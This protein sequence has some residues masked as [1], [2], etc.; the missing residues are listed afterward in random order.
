MTAE[1]IQAPFKL[2]AAQYPIE[3][4]RNLDGWKAKI[5][6]YVEQAVSHGSRIL[7]F[8][9][10]AS[11][12]LAALLDNSTDGDLH[13]QIE[14]MQM[15]SDEYLQHHRRLAE[16][17]QVYITTA[18]FPFRTETGRYQNRVW[19]CSPEGRLGYQDKL[20]MTRF[21][22]EDWSIQAGDSLQLFETRYGRIGILVCYDSEFPLLARR[23]IEQGADIII[24]PSCTDTLAGHHRVRYSCL[25][26]ALENQC[27][28]VQSPTVGMAAWNEAVDINIGAAAI[29]TPMDYGFPANGILAEGELNKA[30]W[31]Y[32]ELDI[33]AMKKLRDNG[34]VLNHRDWDGQMRPELCQVSSYIV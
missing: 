8:P 12:E 4:H 7:V 21:E 2:A 34:Q 26:R 17:H 22:N 27:Y 29:Y 32:A 10:Y 31:V 33:N 15:F 16:R 11:M 24:V 18:S 30:G 28:V 3:R 9:E 20:Q 6:N 14:A 25:A 5:S 23:L 1:T 13:R 19:L